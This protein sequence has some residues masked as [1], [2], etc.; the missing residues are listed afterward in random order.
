MQVQVVNDS[1]EILWAHGKDQGVTSKSYALDGTQDV[2][3]AQLEI[4]LEQAKG[5]MSD[6][7]YDAAEIMVENG[8]ID[9]RAFYN[10]E[11]ENGFDELPCDGAREA[12]G[13]LALLIAASPVEW[14]DN[15]E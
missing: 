1:S 9:P 7:A 6:A 15:E 8:G 11:A 3:I 10:V 14:E 13:A 4:A 12:A 5:E 2:I